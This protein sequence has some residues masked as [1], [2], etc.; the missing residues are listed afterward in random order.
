MKELEYPFDSDYINKKRKSL[1]RQLLAENEG[2]KML[3]KKIAVLGGSTTH[4]VV[5]ILELFLLNQGI[6]PEFYESEY[7]QYWQDMMFDNPELIEFKPDLI[8]IHTSTRN[9]IDFPTVRDSEA[10]IDA[11]LTYMDSL[12]L[13]EDQ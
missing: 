9:I 13:E 5:Q 7:D 11:L 2:T 6:E 3:H 4:D 1:K 10:D 8:Y 12:E